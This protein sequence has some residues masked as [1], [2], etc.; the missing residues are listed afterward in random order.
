VIGDRP[1]SKVKIAFAVIGALIIIAAGVGGYLAYKHHQNTTAA[2]A[3]F[4]FS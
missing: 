4:G 3:M 1:Y 2:L